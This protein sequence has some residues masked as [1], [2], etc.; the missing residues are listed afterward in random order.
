MSVLVLELIAPYFQTL[1]G[2]FPSK[3]SKKYQGEPLFKFS[4]GSFSQ[5]NH[6]IVI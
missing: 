3:L 2:F 4:Y 1:F 6:A 5:K